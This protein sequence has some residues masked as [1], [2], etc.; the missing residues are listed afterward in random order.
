M[1][2]VRVVLSLL[3]CVLLGCSGP[4]R[5]V[6]ADGVVDRDYLA[7]VASGVERL[8]DPHVPHTE[9][10]ARVGVSS[11]HLD[12][13]HLDV[14]PTAPDHG[15]SFASAMCALLGVRDG[16]SFTDRSNNGVAALYEPTQR[17]IWFPQES[18]P[19][20]A[21][22][23]TD[24]SSEVGRDL[25]L[26]F[27]TAHEVAHALQDRRHDLRKFLGEAPDDDAFLARKLFIE[28][29][30]DEI[31]FRYIREVTEPYA[32]RSQLVSRWSAENLGEVGSMLPAVLSWSPYAAG[33]DYA[34]ACGRTGD[35][36]LEPPRSTLELLDAVANARSASTTRAHETSIS[37]GEQPP[38]PGWKLVR[39]NRLGSWILREVLKEEVERTPSTS[40]P[41]RESRVDKTRLERPPRADRYRVYEDERTG[42]L[43]VAWVLSFAEASDA[44][45]FSAR[46]VRFRDL[47]KRPGASR[48]DSS[49]EGRVVLIVE[50]PRPEVVA[51]LGAVVESYRI[52]QE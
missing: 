40:A 19:R 26:E 14:G 36:Y 21:A 27:V 23:W 17:I 35:P 1:D 48:I 18:L 5:L 16:A 31:A 11:S 43:A 44:R 13:E 52:L 49:G 37:L 2:R 28:G 9:L 30:A 41:P 45:E 10:D 20:I 15:R 6:T 51:A 22:L 12:V 32:A 46:Y 8:Y 24:V 29:E 47:R 25:F 3:C 34:R 7:E 42:E 50:G 38:P 4:R 33:V 39:E